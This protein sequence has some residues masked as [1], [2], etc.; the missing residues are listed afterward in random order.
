[1]G[2]KTI[3]VVESDRAILTLLTVAWS[4]EDHIVL[5]AAGGRGAL[6]LA[7]QDKAA[8]RIE[9]TVQRHQRTDS[10]FLQDQGGI[11]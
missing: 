6:S 9:A 3:L 5:P 7:A 2:E 4:S 1:M 11:Y 8:A 10:D